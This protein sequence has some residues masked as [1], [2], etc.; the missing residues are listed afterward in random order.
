MSKI[1]QGCADIWPTAPVGVFQLRQT[2]HGVAGARPLGGAGI[3]RFHSLSLAD[4]EP[5]SRLT[6]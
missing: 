1:R 4:G 6:K 2:A 5:I 3:L